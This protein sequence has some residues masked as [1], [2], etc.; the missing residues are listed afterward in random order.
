MRDTQN[1]SWGSHWER[2]RL[3]AQMSPCVHI[4]S[5]VSLQ[6]CEH[7]ISTFTLN[8]VKSVTL[9]F[10]DAYQHLQEAIRYL[11]SEPLAISICISFFNLN[12]FLAV[13]TFWKSL[14]FSPLC[15]WCFFFFFIVDPIICSCCPYDSLYWVRVKMEIWTGLE[16]RSGVINPQ[17]VLRSDSFSN[18]PSCT[19]QYL[20]SRSAILWKKTKTNSSQ[21]IF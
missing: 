7:E 13:F 6:L 16:T 20:I 11:Q 19:D 5:W 1:H 18:D 2:P 14:F 3:S 10:T 9:A 8:T 21:S 15:N 12:S 17:S 4:N